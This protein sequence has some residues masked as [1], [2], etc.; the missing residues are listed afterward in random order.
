MSG[1]IR[2]CLVEVLYF[3]CFDLTW[4]L[5]DLTFLTSSFTPL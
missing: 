4:S 2:Q 3:W 1:G 5:L